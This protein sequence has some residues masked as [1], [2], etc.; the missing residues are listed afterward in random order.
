M[1]IPVDKLELFSLV[2]FSLIFHCSASAVI[3]VTLNKEVKIKYFNG[4]IFKFSFENNFKNNLAFSNL[5]PMKK[6][7]TQNCQ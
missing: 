7:R 5:L 2:A 4:T 1:I 6:A 3:F